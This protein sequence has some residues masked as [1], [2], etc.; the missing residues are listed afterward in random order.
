MLSEES[1]IAIRTIRNIL[2]N[3]EDHGIVAIFDKYPPADIVA[4][5][6]ALH[7]LQRVTQQYE[8][9]H[10]RHDHPGDLLEVLDDLSHYVLYATAA[11]GWKLDLAFQRKLHMND[12]Q[13]LIRKTGI[14]ENDI[15][16][17]C[18]KSKAHLPVF[19]LARDK[20][21]KT[22]V[23]CIRGTWS[24]RDV[25]TDLCC[26]VDEY[27]GPKPKD[28]VHATPVGNGWEGKPL[29]AHHGM[30]EAAM[31]VAAEVE[32]LIEE[33]LKANPG[34]GLVLVGHSM[35]GGV[36]ALLATIWESRF[37]KM[38]AYLFGGPC[39]ALMSSYPTNQSSIINVISEGDPFRCLSLGHLAD[40]SAAIAKFCE[41]PNLRRSVLKR[42]NKL[43]EDMD[44]EDKRF[45][46]ETMEN[47]RRE[48]MTNCVK[49]Y[50][51]GRIFHV[52]KLIAD[53]NDAELGNGL[54]SNELVIHEVR[55]EY[56]KELLVG[57]RMF[58]VSRHFAPLY[59]TTLRKLVE[60]E[61]EHE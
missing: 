5:F 49:M 30:L 28:D 1:A 57:P 20:K 7:R 16:L 26:N 44:E 46:W 40:I 35:G 19:F 23:L 8:A 59:E 58:D 60:L 55:P 3:A 56:F 48:V 39:V 45:C 13:A 12:K 36:A 4:S 14:E 2:E 51:A 47:I 37:P 34:Y 27:H 53:A 32:E 22:L 52:S 43:L 11:Y 25:L 33:E 21:R 15:L 17:T 50:P 61:Q 18:L 9:E 41:E 29:F 42:S 6:Y 24:P 31:A 38:K 10:T 54:K